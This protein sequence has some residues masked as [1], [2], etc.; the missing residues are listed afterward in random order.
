MDEKFVNRLN[1]WFPRV[2]WIQWRHNGCDGVSNHQCHHCLLKHLFGADQRKHQSSASL[3]FVPVTGEFPAQMASNAENVSIWWRHHGFGLI[4]CHGLLYLDTIDC[5][6]WHV[7]MGLGLDTIEWSTIQPSYIVAQ[8][9]TEK[10]GQY[11][12]LWCP[13][14]LNRQ[15]ISNHGIDCVK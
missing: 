7:G 3:A 5:T 11:H 1:H 2:K 4:G 15:A 6:Q 13:G 14:F 12:G 9:I 10:L 8:I